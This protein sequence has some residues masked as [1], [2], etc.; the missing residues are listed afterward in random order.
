MIAFDEFFEINF[1]YAKARF[2]ARK[3]PALMDRYEAY[4]KKI[5]IFDFNPW[6]DRLQDALE[7]AY[8]KNDPSL[9]ERARRDFK[10]YYD[11]KI[12]IKIDP[13]T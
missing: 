10:P 4:R 8:F 13:A 5:E 12:A 1:E 6:I 7:Y 2:D 11:E 3:D 9:I